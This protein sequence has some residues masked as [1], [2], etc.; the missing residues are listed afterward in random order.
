MCKASGTDYSTLFSWG[1]LSYPVKE[2]ILQKSRALC[3]HTPSI[4]IN[5]E[6]LGMVEYWA[7]YFTLF[8]S[9]VIKGCFCLKSL[10]S[11][12]FIWGH[13][14]ACGWIDPWCFYEAK[15]SVTLGC[16][17]P[18]KPCSDGRELRPPLNK[19][20]K[21][22]VEYKHKAHKHKDCLNNSTG[23]QITCE[24]CWNGHVMGSSLCS[25][26]MNARREVYPARRKH[27]ISSRAPIVSLDGLNVLRVASC[28]CMFLK[29]QQRP[30][31]YGITDCPRLS[32]LSC[33][34]HTAARTV[35][36]LRLASS[37]LLYL[38]AIYPDP[39]TQ[40]ALSVGCRGRGNIAVEVTAPDIQLEEWEI[41][42]H[43]FC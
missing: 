15:A 32:V 10:G 33:L 21:H 38:C 3:L 24:L 35:W 23:I 16:P 30:C 37:C 5:T 39:E 17:F 14:E 41:C 29:P 31:K 18:G 22:S 43:T 34:K 20:F 8:T 4:D 42:H 9:R 2:N 6:T 7:T 12:W 1:I 26:V 28:P 25:P 40:W 11:K 19:A 36:I 27:E 13:T